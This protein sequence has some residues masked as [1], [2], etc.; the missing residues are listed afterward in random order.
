M[1]SMAKV[2][3]IEIV[4]DDTDFLIILH[5]ILHHFKVNKLR[6]KSPTVDVVMN[7]TLLSSQSVSIFKMLASLPDNVTAN[8]LEVHCLS[9]CDTAS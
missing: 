5:T 1:P 4:S 2:R 9:G 3:Q 6:K 8:L 7:T